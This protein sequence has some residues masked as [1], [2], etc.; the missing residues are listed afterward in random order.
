[1]HNVVWPFTVTRAAQPA[2]TVLSP[3]Q[4][5][6]SILLNTRA[7]QVLDSLQRV[8]YDTAAVG[9]VRRQVAALRSGQPP[10]APAGGRGGGG[11]G[12]GGPGGAF[13]VYSTCHH[14]M[15]QWDTFCARPVEVPVQGGGGRGAGGGGGGG[16]GGAASADVGPIQRIWGI[17]GMSPPGG[18]GGGGRAGFGGFGG[19]VA[20][21]GDYLVTLSI[22]GQTYKQTFRVEQT[23]NAGVGSPFSPQEE[24]KAKA[25]TK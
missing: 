23:N 2:A 11:G 12:R 10:Q 13:G 5:R 19:N 21:T 1:V 6:D 14:P 18:G 8:G 7:P 3:S 25:K 17:I 16:R 22:G 15:T 9:A 4:R 20:P 24:A